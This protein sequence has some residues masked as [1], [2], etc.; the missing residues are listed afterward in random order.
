MSRMLSI[1]RE[2]PGSS[3]RA[4][5]LLQVKM[6]QVT[7]H[8]CPASCQSL[9]SKLCLLVVVPFSSDSVS[10]IEFMGNIS[11]EPFQTSKE[12]KGTTPGKTLHNHREDLKAVSHT[13]SGVIGTDLNSLL[14]Q[15]ESNTDV[16]RTSAPF[17]S[18]QSTASVLPTS[19]DGMNA[20]ALGD[21]VCSSI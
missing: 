20:I 5:Q 6:E 2:V 1:M 3:N 14:L 17:C 15:L 9:L 21:L 10:T 12:G 8:S 19:G 16:Q 7:A 11:E 18:T 13:R 4:K